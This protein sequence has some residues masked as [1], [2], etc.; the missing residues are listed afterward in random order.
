MKKIYF[1][2]IMILTFSCQDFVEKQPY[3]IIT[4]AT[5]IQD[6]ESAKGAILGMYSNFQDGNQYGNFIIAVPGVLSDE[7]IHSGSFPTV[8]E[9][10]Q[11]EVIPTNV[12]I[13][14]IWASHYTGIYIANTVLER[15]GT[16]TIDPTLKSQL[17][18][19][20]LFGR[21]LFH[22][23]L[24][25]LFGGVPLAKET[26][27]DVLRSISR[28]TLAETFDFIISDLNQAAT[29]LAGVDHGS[30]ADNKNRATDWAAKALLARVH[31]Y[32]GDLV[33][34][35]TYA[36]E[37]I[38]SGKFSLEANY[39]DIFGGNASSESI[40]QI[41]SS[42]ND[43]NGAAFWFRVDGR[44]EYAPSTEFQNA[45]EAGDVRAAVIDTQSGKVAAAKYVDVGTGTDQS[46]VL[47]LAEMYLIRAEANLGA[48]QAD[49]DVNTIRSRAKLGNKTNVTLDDILQ[50]RFIELSFE[51]H[52][53]HDLVRT[54]KVSTVMSVINPLT[55]GSNDVLM[56]IPQY[57]IDQN[58]SLK[59]FQN[60]GY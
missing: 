54:N 11:N 23:N 22:F 13:R 28:A 60:P 44:Y 20:A 10:D 39:M 47:R 34:A 29:L 33:T 2:T 31:L 57:E 53:W 15:I 41:F 12:N 1:L 50:E 40:F 9:M 27:L 8:A 51:G 46:I 36:N 38:N 26:N 59:G 58:P 6:E 7:L 48:I 14:N 25:N 52:R 18:G 55:W 56:P 4:D 19:E 37:V 43:Q 3:D 16:I 45:I 32:K 5:V 35:G 30:N 42:T 21:A 17:Q 49:N 24:A